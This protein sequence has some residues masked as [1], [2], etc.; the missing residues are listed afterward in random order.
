MQRGLVSY[1]LGA[2]QRAGTLA[3]V[4]TFGQFGVEA[5]VAVAAGFMS[6]GN[7]LAADVALCAGIIALNQVGREGLTGT[8]RVSGVGA[9]EKDPYAVEGDD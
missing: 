1:A 9:A 3:R 5:T 4:P 8:P 7:D 6:K 2:A